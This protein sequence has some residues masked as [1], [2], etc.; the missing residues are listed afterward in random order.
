M[1]HERGRGEFHLLLPP[2]HGCSIQDMNQKRGTPPTIPTGNTTGPAT[3]FPGALA[4]KCIGN[5][6]AGIQTSHSMWDASVLSGGL[7]YFKMATPIFSSLNRYI[8][9][10]LAQWCNTLIFTYSANIKYGCQFMSQLVLF[11]FRS[12]LMAGK[13]TPVLTLLTWETQ[14]ILILDLISSG[15]GGHLEDESTME[16]FSLLSHLSSASLFLS[17]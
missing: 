3:T 16:D 15:C 8:R 2:P 9:G 11:W 7:T 1:E 6:V 12:M 14:K 4:G 17:L 13:A 5:G 10:A